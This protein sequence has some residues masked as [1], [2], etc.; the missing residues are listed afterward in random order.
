MRKQSFLLSAIIL[1][2]GGVV[3]K[4]VGALYKVPLTHILGSNGMGVYYLIFPIYSLLL[5]VCSSGISTAVSKN[6]SDQVALNNRINQKRIL[7][8]SLLISFGLSLVFSVLVV[9]F[10]SSIAD[11]QGNINA[12]WGYIAI[13]PALVCASLITIIKAYFQ[14]LNNMTPSSIIIIFEQVFKLIM[15]LVLSTQFLQKGL[16]YGVFGAVLGV[17]IS[18]VLTLIVVIFIY[19]YNVK[20]YNLFYFQL[21]SVNKYTFKKKLIKKGVEVKKCMHNIKHT[22][23]F[24]NNYKMPYRVVFKRILK[25]SFFATFSNLIVPLSSFIDSFLIINLLSNS[26]F[27][28]T[29]ST[30]L[31]GISNGIISSLISLPVMV[32]VSL[33]TVIVPNLSRVVVVEGKSV[34]KQKCSFFIK[35]S[36]VISLLLFVLF[37]LFSNEIIEILFSKGLNNSAVNEFDYT[38]KMLMVSS[39]SI[40]YYGFLQTFI[41]ILNALDKYVIPVVALS[42]ALVI[43]IALMV[44]LVKN[45][46]INIFGAVISQ[47]VFLAI[48]SIICLIYLKRYINIEFRFFRG[49]VFPA[50]CAVITF[51]IMFCVKMVLSRWLNIWI[52]C[53]ICGLLTLIVFML[54]IRYFKIFNKFE[55]DYLNLK[56]K[57][58]SFLAKRIW[59]TNIIK[60][61]WNCFK[62]FLIIV[63]IQCNSVFLFGINVLV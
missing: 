63:I 42:G 5:V 58:I 12:N 55:N 3:A 60:N 57:K 26:G 62:H 45:P 36:W 46:S 11:M 44:V 49:G 14:G 8:V 22:Y 28:N 34:L 20:K 27:S 40:I 13:A 25:F 39:V 47:V 24:E 16:A 38:Y 29:I 23:Y 48:A 43:R 30:S 10:S 15:G 61:V 2:I 31:Y 6:I 53:G 32:L 21:K 37:I 4:I 59:K 52:Y 17:T 1:V 51:G 7:N 56:F 19:I 18:E 9:V 33:S 35:F 54:L 41:A 50:M